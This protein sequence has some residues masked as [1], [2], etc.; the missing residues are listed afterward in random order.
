MQHG[1]DR[2]DLRYFRCASCGAINRIPAERIADGPTC[3]RCRR[4]IDT[5][6]RPADV[7]DA[8]ARATIRGAPTP[9]LLDFWA[10]WCGPCR[11]VAPQLEQLAARRAGRLIVLK[12]N[13]EQHQQL[14]SELGVRAI[15]TLALYRGGRLVARQAGALMGAALERFV[16]SNA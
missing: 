13:T 4:A 14:A 5:S 2:A 16:A 12:L 15:P 3:G 6:A 1:G 9:V 10:P 7:S 11:A 8:A